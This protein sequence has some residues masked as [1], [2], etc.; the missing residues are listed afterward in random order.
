MQ[1]N[2]RLDVD[3]RNL[4]QDGPQ[5]KRNIATVLSELFEQNSLEDFSD[6]QE[7]GIL[8]NEKQQKHRKKAIRRT[9]KNSKLSVMNCIFIR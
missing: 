4:Y 1:K 2:L 9:T 8:K 5:V 6:D 3:K 7:G